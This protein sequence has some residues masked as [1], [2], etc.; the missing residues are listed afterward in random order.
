MRIE[1]LE[2]LAEVA[3]LGSFCRTAESLHVSP[4]CAPAQLRAST[5]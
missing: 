4:G 2:H 3:R 1:Q 5:A